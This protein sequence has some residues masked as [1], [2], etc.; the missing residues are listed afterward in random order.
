MQGCGICGGPLL[1]SQKRTETD[2]GPAHEDLPDCFA[3]VRH[4]ERKRCA[5][6]ARIWA[7][8][9]FEP[10]YIVVLFRP[11]QREAALSI[12]DKIMEGW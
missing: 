3:H 7:M 4:E 1:V 6:V 2:H 10:D 11:G 12:A 5:N 8:R 9:K